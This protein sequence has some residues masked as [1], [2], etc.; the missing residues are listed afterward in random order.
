M[1]EDFKN[2]EKVDK[3][4]DTKK[5]DNIFSVSESFAIKVVKN[6]ILDSIEKRA[7]DVFIETLED[8]LR[9]RY[10]VDGLLHEAGRYLLEE[11]PYIITAIKV[12]SDLDVAEH[13]LPQDG[14]FRFNIKDRN[15]DFRVSVLPTNLGEKIVLRVL[16]KERLNLDLDNLGFDSEA[17]EI[18]KRNLKKPYGMIVVCGAT[19]SGKTTTLYSCIKFI[20]SPKLNIVTIED[21]VEFQL[22]GINQVQVQED[23]GLTFAAALRSILRQDPNVILVGEIRDLE[24]A[25]IAIKASLTGHLVLST[26]HTTTSTAAMVRFINMGIEP[27]LVASSCLISASQTLLRKVCEYCK[28]KTAIPDVLKKELENRNITIP[29]DFEYYKPS[30]CKFCNNTGY[31]GRIGIIE[32]FEIDQ[33]I[34]EAIISNKTEIEIRRLAIK[35]GMLTLREK[36]LKKV[37]DGLTTLEEVYRTTID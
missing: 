4:E 5:E 37:L 13:R 21:P 3:K 25:D 28:K 36:A 33:E 9:I 8:C 32:I 27:F 10:R 12:I 16:D 19:G 26:L 30:G 1:V 15:V 20:N 6:I 14:H 35:K 34:R 2:K 18:L 31:S 7:S 22:P 11:A 24:T 23:I 17:V 29:K